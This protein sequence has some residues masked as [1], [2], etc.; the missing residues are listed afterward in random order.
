V[1]APPAHCSL[2]RGT[3]PSHRLSAMLSPGCGEPAR[4]SA[5]KGSAETAAV[6]L[7]PASACDQC[8]NVHT[9]RSRWSSVG[10][11]SRMTC[12][13]RDPRR[14][15]VWARMG[16]VNAGPIRARRGGPGA[17]GRARAE[18]LKRLGH[19]VLVERASSVTGAT[20]SGPS[21]RALLTTAVLTKSDRRTS[22]GA[23]RRNSWSWLGRSSPR[24][25]QSSHVCRLRTTSI[26]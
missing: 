4:L 13:Q 18:Q 9:E 17:N 21:W 7:L 14:D 19:I 2:L 26:R 1:A 8:A 20:S 5:V 23:G 12:G 24:P 25:S 22:S 16:L 15:K 3:R 10:G 11:D 6:I